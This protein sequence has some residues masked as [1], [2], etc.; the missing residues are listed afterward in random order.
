MSEITPL[1]EYPMFRKRLYRAHYFVVAVLG[2][3]Q[4]WFAS[5]EGGQPAWLL[6]ALA[7]AAYVGG[8]LGVVADRNVGGHT[9]VEEVG[10]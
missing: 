10:E 3:L 8:V 9:A 7:V 2:G 6:P 5:T 4:V 1:E